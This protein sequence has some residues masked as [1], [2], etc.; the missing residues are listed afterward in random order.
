MARGTIEVFMDAF[1]VGVFDLEVAI[2]AIG[3]SLHITHAFFSGRMT[4]RA[5][6]I[7][8]IMDIRS[9]AFGQGIRSTYISSSPATLHRAG[10]AH[11]RAPS[12][13][14]A[15]C[16]GWLIGYVM[17]PLLRT[18]IIMAIQ[19]PHMAYI[20]IFLFGYCLLFRKWDIDL[21]LNVFSILKGESRAF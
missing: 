12:V 15:A 20:A 18:W 10:V 1:C 19:A 2:L 13:A 4:V 5:M 17:K 16:R 9:H 11:A 8:L 14:V 7:L 6:D 21:L 3:L